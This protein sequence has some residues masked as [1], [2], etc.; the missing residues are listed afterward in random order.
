MVTS[1]ALLLVL[2]ANVKAQP[3]RPTVACTAEL[4]PAGHAEIELGGFGSS[5]ATSVN[6]LAKVSL[7]DWL[8]VQLGSD[9]FLRVEGGQ[10][11]AIDGAV[12]FLKGRLLAQDGWV[13]TVS[14]S[15]KVAMPTRPP[16][17]AAQSSV[18]LGGTLHLSKDLGPLHADLNGT[19]LVAGLREAQ[20]QGA[21]AVSTG[22]PG[23]FGV[24]L[25]VHS[26]FG[27]PRL[28]NDGGLRAVLTWSAADFLVFDLG[29]DLGFFRQTRAWSVFAG[30]VF[31]PTFTKQ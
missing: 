23:D 17:P 5:D 2:T 6:V 7:L 12:G 30:L 20:G 21:L 31:V 18:D 27:N 26:T 29:G 13:P 14:A 24:A 19:L 4:V 1:A 28:S 8:Q 25:E 3:C 16:L 11:T 9:H 15:L 22:L 10:L